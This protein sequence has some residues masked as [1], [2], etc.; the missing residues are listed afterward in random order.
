MRHMQLHF[1]QWWGEE[2]STQLISEME[3]GSRPSPVLRQL[4]HA[5]LQGKLNMCIQKSERTQQHFDVCIESWSFNQ[6]IESWD[7]SRQSLS[8]LKK[9]KFLW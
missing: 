5:S 6:E 8:A 3:L 1:M 4:T 7:H 9:K 2:H